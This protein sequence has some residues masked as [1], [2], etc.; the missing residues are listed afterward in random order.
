MK[1]ERELRIVDEEGLHMR[2][3]QDFVKI[4]NRYRCQVQ[5]NLNGREADGKSLLKMIEL[6]GH[7]GS[8]LGLVTDGADAPA[9]MAELSRFVEDGFPK[10]KKVD[11]KKEDQGGDS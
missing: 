7:P 9:A 3:A 11:E 10:Q 8:M 1:L 6:S 4:A 5:V 2:P